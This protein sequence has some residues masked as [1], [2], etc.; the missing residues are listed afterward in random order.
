MTRKRLQ[1]LAVPASC[2]VLG[3]TIGYVTGI[4]RAGKFDD[5]GSSISGVA[6]EEANARSRMRIRISNT[7][8]NSVHDPDR[9]VAAAP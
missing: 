1:L 2:L 8:V 5:R 4:H 9:P 6:E 3:L 7:H